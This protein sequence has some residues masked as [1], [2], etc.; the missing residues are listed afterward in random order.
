MTSSSCRRDG[1]RGWVRKGLV[2]EWEGR[3]D[4]GW[5]QGKQSFKNALK[6][7]GTQSQLKNYYDHFI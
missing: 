2:W 1:M 3:D 6:T 7:H 5:V 4:L